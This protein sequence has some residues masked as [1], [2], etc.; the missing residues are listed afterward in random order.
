MEQDFIDNQDTEGNV[1][2]EKEK[3]EKKKKKKK[4]KKKNCAIIIAK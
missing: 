4:K 2:L 3:K 1:V